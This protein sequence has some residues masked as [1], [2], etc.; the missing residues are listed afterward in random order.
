MFKKFKDIFGSIAV[1]FTLILLMLAATTAIAVV[2]SYLVFGNTSQQLSGL[3]RDRLPELRRS[4]ALVVAAS[5][6]Q[7][8][9]AA[10]LA[11]TELADLAEQRQNAQQHIDRLQGIIDQLGDQHSVAIQPAL[12]DVAQNLPQLIE[13]R[14]VDFETEEA[15]SKSINDWRDQ[16]ARITERVIELSDNAFF[17]LTIGGEET[18]GR[19]DA[20]LRS[21]VENDVAALQLALQAKSEISLLSGVAIAA[22][23]VRDPSVKSILRDL[24]ESSL[25]RLENLMAA[26]A[27]NPRLELDLEQLN[28][29]AEVF[30][31]ASAENAIM[32]Q[33]LRERILSERQKSDAAISTAVDNAIFELT[34]NS[35]L[36]SS[37]NTDAIQSLLSVQVKNLRDLAELNIAKETYFATILEVAVAQN[38]ADLNVTSQTLDTSYAALT[39]LLASAD[40]ELQEMFQPLLSAHDEGTG[41]KAL[42]GKTISAQQ[43]TR[44]LSES[45][46]QSVSEIA[47]QA[48]DIGQQSVVLI[49]QTATDITS[50]VVDAKQQ[51]VAVA[52][53]CIGLL[54]VTQI[55][56]YFVV[57]RPI[58]RLTSTT[59]RLAA[60]D[61]EPVVGFDEMS[62]EIG[63]MGRALKVFR[64]GMVET[65]QLRLEEEQRKADEIEKQRLIEQ[66]KRD[67]EEAERE[68]ALNAE[69]AER[70]R[71][72]AEE[73][74][75][76]RLRKMA[77]AERQAHADEQSAVVT[78]L[79]DGLKKLAAGNLDA[80]INEEFAGSYEDLRKDY[81][82]AVGQLAT[83]IGNIT[84]SGHTIADT[85]T[86]ISSAA[87]DLS[88]RTE[89]TAA[90]LEEAAA[91]LE[92][93]TASVKQASEGAVRVDTVVKHAKDNAEKSSKVVENTIVAMGQIETSS[94]KIAKIVDLIDDIAFQTNLLALNAGVEAARAGDA[95]RGFAVVA[96]E[97]RNLAQRSSDAAREIGQLIS[98]SGSQVS[99]GVELV[100]ETGQA[101]DAIVVSVSEI[102]SQIAEIVTAAQ[103][104]SHGIT[105][106]NQTVSAIEQSTQQNAAMVEETTAASVS[107]KQQADILAQAISSFKIPPQFAKGEKPAM[108]DSQPEPSRRKQK[109]SVVSTS[110]NLAE[111]AEIDDLDDD[112]QDF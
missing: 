111:V 83:V 14:V 91:A 89:N 16:S 30:R 50:D 44:E 67:R 96:S 77:D 17:D 104:Q 70:E 10:T 90:T 42:R 74:E 29:T 39:G 87:S 5:D 2:L 85:S 63:R 73:A 40:A 21:I 92:Q 25:N 20:T 75:R 34:I 76:D 28:Q 71:L 37:E 4:T 57:I 18:V 7:D 35:E 47:N 69:K 103:E 108:D 19:V 52:I 32:T 11:A 72:A 26:I 93:L 81:N 3:S 15:I 66:E 56:T 12:E 82:V 79:A 94:G 33:A 112:W 65:N 43:Q 36:A 6:L 88:K 99:R 60:Q 68:A 98:E 23:Q 95:G 53:A 101:L 80:Q 49:E 8:G 27:E 31:R 106:I 102:A 62:G 110:G 1:K 45:A 84:S 59:E 100:G 58:K 109:L 97:V 61:L 38:A 78:A 9:L 48:A 54:V 55:M 105:E 86:E 64:D 46:L 51:M 22:A 107:M 24:N 13:A 41:I